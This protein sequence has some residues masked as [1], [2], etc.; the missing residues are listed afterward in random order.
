MSTGGK[1]VDGPQN[2]FRRSE[3]EEVTASCLLCNHPVTSSFAG[4]AFLANNVK[5][6]KEAEDWSV[7]L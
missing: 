4:P 3:E 2:Y 7:V 5:R 1:G 6:T